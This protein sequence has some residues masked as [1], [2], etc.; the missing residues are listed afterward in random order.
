MHLKALKIDDCSNGWGLLHTLLVQLVGLTLFVLGCIWLYTF[1]FT[2]YRTHLAPVMIPLAVLLVLFS[3]GLIFLL[4]IFVMTSLVLASVGFL[5]ALYIQ[6]VSLQLI[7]F[8]FAI[9]IVA[10]IYIAML[11]PPIYRRIKHQ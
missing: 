7:P 4:K 6:I 1:S 5:F 11:T 10:I 8:L 2:D 3:L 9:C